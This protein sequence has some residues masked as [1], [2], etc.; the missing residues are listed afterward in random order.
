M[1]V[2]VGQGWQN[3][4]FSRIDNDILRARQAGA[5]SDNATV[6]DGDIGSGSRCA[7]EGQDVAAL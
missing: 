4:C 7:A 2:D 1:G 5:D 3:D 6:S